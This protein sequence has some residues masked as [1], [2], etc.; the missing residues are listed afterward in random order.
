M[1]SRAEV[2]KIREGHARGG[3]EKRARETE[4]E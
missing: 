1:M 4:K 3:G 2:R